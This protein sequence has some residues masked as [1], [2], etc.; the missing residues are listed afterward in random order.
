MNNDRTT[1]RESLWLA[2]MLAAYAL[3]SLVSLRWYPVFVDE[4]GYADPAAS[5]L[6]GQG[7][8]SGAWY[9]QGYESFWAGNVPLHQFLLFFW[10][11]VFGFSQVA[12]RS[13]N[14]PYVVMGVLLFHA[15]VRRLGIITSP[16]WRLAFVGLMLCSHAGSIWISLGRTDAICVAL[17]G[18][19]A[20]GLSLQRV[21][22]RMMVVLVAG[23][24]APW[25]GIQLAVVLGFAGTMMLVFF[26]KR[27]GREILSLA[28]G[29]I[30]GTASL[31]ALYLSNG[32]LGE[33]IQ[34]VL[35]HSPIGLAER[36][37]IPPPVEGLKHRI[38]GFTDYSLLCLLVSSAVAGLALLRR[39]E[40][41]PWLLGGASALGGI[42]AVLALTGVFPM[43]YAWFAFIPGAA[44]LLAIIERGWI[45]NKAVRVLVLLVLTCACLIGFPRVWFMGFLYR[46]DEANRLAEEFVSSA[47]QSGDTVLVQPIAWYGAKRTAAR[48]YHGFRAPNLTADEVARLNVVIS[49]PPFFKAQGSIIGSNWAEQPQRL[50]VPNRNTHRLPFSKWYRDNPNLEMHVYR[51]NPGPSAG[52]TSP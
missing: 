14:I 22:L 46:A 51:R 10:M 1:N 26:R 32:V 52:S 6:L 24:F 9:A 38:G 48:V 45:G 5:L 37:V 23:M 49:S 42:P 3:L 12:V 4:P 44:I 28:V 40:A 2:L 16:G 20:F 30:I 18:L 35:P 47:L 33:F 7:F 29:G 50:S 15:T 8:T 43:Y 34:S 11:K 39:R 25:A 36:T 21:R 41:L 13:I 27:F 31:L 17:A 19:F